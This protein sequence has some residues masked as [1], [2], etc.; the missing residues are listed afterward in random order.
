MQLQCVMFLTLVTLY[1][2]SLHHLHCYSSLL[3]TLV[4]LFPTTTLIQSL[5]VASLVTLIIYA[6]I[7]III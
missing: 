7:Y 2:L 5:R 1:L 4:S 3:G 6:G